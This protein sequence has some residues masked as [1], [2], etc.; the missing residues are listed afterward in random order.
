LRLAARRPEPAPHRGLCQV[1]S[2]DLR[3]KALALEKMAY[4]HMLG[5]DMS[6][7]A[8]HVVEAR[9]VA[10]SSAARPAEHQP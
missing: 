1:K 7:A 9:G 2:T 6:W 5:Y 4:L 10:T 3:T 8:F